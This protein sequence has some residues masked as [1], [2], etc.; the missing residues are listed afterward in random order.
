[1]RRGFKPLGT[2]QAET[3]GWPQPL[4]CLH[5]RRDITVQDIQESR[6]QKQKQPRAPQQLQHEE[7]QGKGDNYTAS[8]PGF[9]CTFSHREQ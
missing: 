4:P 6:M 5:P 9:S 7:Q 2:H 3:A 1:M 8:F